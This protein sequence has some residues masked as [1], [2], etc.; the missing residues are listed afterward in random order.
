MLAEETISK[1]TR[2]RRVIRIVLILL[3]KMMHYD[4]NSF[5]H[6]PGKIS[7]TTGKFV[8]LHLLNFGYSYTTLAT[9]HMID[10]ETESRCIQK[11]VRSRKV[12]GEISTN[13][14]KKRKFEAT[15]ITH[16]ISINFGL[17]LSTLY[18]YT[19]HPSNMTL[20]KGSVPA[21]NL[22]F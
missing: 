4:I 17:G 2:G 14:Q 11:V 16:V 12:H 1:G 10:S 5:I 21:L 22:N 6:F 8:L 3:P 20:R 9:T 15:S 13:K 18:N 19:Q 7:A